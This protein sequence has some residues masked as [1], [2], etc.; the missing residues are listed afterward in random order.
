MHSKDLEVHGRL[1]G[2]FDYLAA[3]FAVAKIPMERKFVAWESLGLPL[4]FELTIVAGTVRGA[5]PTLLA[6][7]DAPNDPC[8]VGSGTLMSVLRDRLVLCPK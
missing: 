4:W 2:R 7:D 1:F 6:V 8:S 3:F 5:V